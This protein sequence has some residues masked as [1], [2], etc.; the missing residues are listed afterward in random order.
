MMLVSGAFAQTVSCPSDAKRNNGN[1]CLT[2]GGLEVE[3]LTNPPDN[4]QIFA[5]LSSQG[6][7]TVVETTRAESSRAGKWYIDW[8]FETDNIGPVIQGSVQFR[9][10]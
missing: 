7:A 5:I 8:C 2:G 3:F 4:L 10:L 6:T 9:I 1:N